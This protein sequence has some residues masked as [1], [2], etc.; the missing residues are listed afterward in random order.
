MSEKTQTSFDC[1][2]GRLQNK[3]ECGSGYP[4]VK[5]L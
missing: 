3:K 4:T 5:T 2:E 1:A